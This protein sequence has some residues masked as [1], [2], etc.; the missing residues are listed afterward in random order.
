MNA[1]EAFEVARSAKE[2]FD[3]HTDAD[4]ATKRLILALYRT[5]EAM[6]EPSQDAES[7]SSPEPKKRKE[8]QAVGA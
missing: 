1:R 5:I 3:R 4:S 6:V 2:S 7:T 8:K